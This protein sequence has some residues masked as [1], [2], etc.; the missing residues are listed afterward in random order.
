[1]K[2][3]ADDGTVYHGP[4]YTKEEQADIEARCRGTVAFSSPSPRPRPILKVRTRP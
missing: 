1:M 2:H 3:I 4:P